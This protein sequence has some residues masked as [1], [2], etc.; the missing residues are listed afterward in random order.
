MPQGISRGKKIVAKITPDMTEANIFAPLL[1]QEK[2]LVFIHQVTVKTSIFYIYL[3]C[4]GL[5][6]QRFYELERRNTLCS[7]IQAY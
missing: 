3:S 2:Y 7:V 5:K 1:P 4:P 6:K